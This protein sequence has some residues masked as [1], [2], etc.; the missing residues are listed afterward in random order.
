VTTTPVSQGRQ[1]ATAAL[2]IAVGNITSRL[3]GVVREAVFAAVYGRGVEL[4]AFTAAAT[5]PTLVYD[6][7][8]SGAMSAALVPVLSRVAHQPAQRDRL[9][10]QVLSL[11]VVVAT[12]LVLPIF[13]LAPQV[14]AWVAGGFDEPAQA[15]TTTMVRWMVFAVPCMVV[16]GV[17]T[18]VLQAQQ[19]FVL[20]A[21]VTSVFNIGLIVGAVVLTPWLGPVAL[22][23]GMLLGALA[24]V[25]LQWYGLRGVAL[26]WNHEW[27]DPALRE[28]LRL[29][30]PV[31]VGM[32]FSALGTMIDR[33]LGSEYGAQVLPTMRYATTLIQFP[34]GLVA[35]AVSTAILPTL[36]RLTDSS[37]IEQFRTTVA[38]ALTV[39]V[40]LIVPAAVVLWLVRVPLTALILQ[41][42][43]FVAADTQAVADTLLWYIPGLPAAAI[44]Q[45]L[46]FACYARG[47]TL[48]PNL[49]QGAAIG[50]YVVGVLVGLPFFGQSAQTLAFANSVQWIT[51]M[52]LMVVLAHRLFDLRRLGLPLVA[53]QCAMAGAVCAV[54]VRAAATAAGSSSWPVVVQLIVLS[55]VAVVGYAVL[56]WLFRI[57]PVLA[58][59]RLVYDKVRARLVRR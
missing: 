49:I 26:R 27:R 22:A 36:A 54:V 50:G 56:A 8:L 25:G 21:F 47:R 33:R 19:R 32:G 3:I 34:L 35:A 24:Q 17:M 7:L 40:A 39:V 45:I 20:P 44:D 51:H 31:A 57:T 41:R 53:A 16:A 38:Q 52:L 10:S 59:Y 23:G 42:N 48:A 15:L 43:A 5:I 1:I 37:A 13:W 4:A 55:G 28:M 2:F 6:L 11:L 12:G 58:A 9:V 46:L 14:V 18:A 30:A 29:Y